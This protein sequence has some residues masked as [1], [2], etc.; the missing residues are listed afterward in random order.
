MTPILRAV[1]RETA[2]TVRDQGRSRPLV[3]ELQQ[4]GMLLRLKG[5]RGRYLLPYAV[6]WDR[7]VKLAVENERWTLPRRRR[8]DAAKPKGDAK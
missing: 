3:V 2:T 1:V 4:H 6:A 8:T 7:A 5:H